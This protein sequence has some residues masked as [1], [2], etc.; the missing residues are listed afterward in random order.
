MVT[1]ALANQATP[2]T[3]WLMR[4]KAVVPSADTP[5]IE[6]AGVLVEGDQIVAMGQVAD[7]PIPSETAVVDLK[8]LT[9][10]P[11][12]IDAHV[13]LAFDSSLTPARVV[14]EGDDVELAWLVSDHARRHLERGVTTIRDLG[15]RGHLVSRLRDAIA[16]GRTRGPRIL[17]SDAPVTVTG[18]HCWYMSEE[19][20][21]ETSL[22]RAVRRRA[23][24]RAD[25]VKVMLT[26][27]FMYPQ[28][29]APHRPVYDVTVLS[30]AVSEARTLGLRVTAHA[31]G[32][33]GIRVALQAGVDTIEHATM[34][35]RD[36]VSF[37]ATL[38]RSM[39]EAGVI[40]VPTLNR[41][42]LED[43]L[44]WASA[45]EALDILRR[46]HETG[47]RLAVGT[48]GGIDGV[49]HGDYAAAVQTLRAA[50]LTNA[51]AYHAATEH[52]AD[53]CGLK[54]DVGRLAVG[55]VADLV[56]VD[57]DPRDDLSV[58]DTPRYV[59]AAGIPVVASSPGNGR[60]SGA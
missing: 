40:V 39:A 24:D 30:R 28:A 50:G 58:L 51:E 20:D 38:A 31:H 60:G 34:T 13:H 26:G 43:E 53:A 48:D 27:G 37:D 52:T 44:P 47:V 42:W 57:R 49:D 23:R 36:G 21:D 14:R 19:C 3:P 32:V 17:A 59:V 6:D 1:S 10:V 35:T 5:A 4:A 11:G 33:E 16:T 7:I 2:A 41:R 15:C 46:L 18:G 25:V 9:L 54:G 12:F 29:E 45:K 55:G 8:G 22:L 56:A